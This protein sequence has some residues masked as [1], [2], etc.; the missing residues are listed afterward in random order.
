MTGPSRTVVLIVAGLVAAAA[1]SDD[2]DAGAPATTSGAPSSAPT[3]TAATGSVPTT[4][5]PTTTAATPL[6]T[7]TTTTTTTTAAAAGADPVV[8]A[9]VVAELEA[10]TDLTWRAGDPAL[11]VTEQGGRVMRVGDG[12]PAVVLDMTDLTTAERERGLLGVAIDPTG[13]NAY[14]NYTD[15]DGNTVIAEHPVGADGTFL[16]GDNSRTVLQIEQPYANHNGGDLT[17]GPDGYLYIG[18]GDGGSG[19]DPERRA[20]DLGSLLG[21]IL[22]ID[23]AITTGEAYGVPPDNPF[24]GTDAAPE[25]WALG[26]R[27]PWRIAFD[28]DTGYLWIADVGEEA[29][30]EIDVAPAVEGADAGRGLNF[31]WSAFEGNEPFNDD[32]TVEGHASPLYTYGHD[33]GCSVSG[34]VRARGQAAGSLHGWYV[35]ADYCA[36]TVWALEVGSDSGGFTAGRRVTL[37]TDI[38]QPT[39][40]VDG[41]HGEV[42]VLSQEGPV[43]RLDA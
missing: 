15:N 22:R 37:T 42:Y 23:P 2:D 18:T 35:F 25:I 9:T 36:G 8:T 20:S 39:A 14:V 6:T 38:A 32:V 21:K 34:G 17:F 33:E 7:T 3:T 1:C 41:P 10:P 12:E 24:V 26:L 40:V 28:R 43:Y 4:T 30:E 16:T 5:A 29:I 11:Y 31:G 19:G 13:A 27:N